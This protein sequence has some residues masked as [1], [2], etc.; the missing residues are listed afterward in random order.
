MSLPSRIACRADVERLLA[1][2]A[3]FEQALPSSSAAFDLLRMERLLAALGHPERGPRTWHV[4]GSK[5]KGSTARMLAAGLRAAGL[6]PVGLTTSPHLV[7]LAERIEVDGRPVDDELLCRAF[8]RL[9]PWM[10]ATLGGRL[11][12][13]FFELVTAAAWLAFRARDCRSV[14][15]E[16]GL[17]GRLDA[18]NVCRPEGTAITTIELEHVA[19]L[20]DT[21]EAI[22]AEK[23]GILKPGVPCAT[24]AGGGALRVIEQRAR[25]VGAPLLR[26][27]QEITLEGV[28]PGAGLR[29]C[30]QVQALGQRVALDLPL[31]G[32]HQARN[33]A[34]AT[35]LL[36]QAGVPAEAVREGLSRVRLPA[37]LELF[38]G[39][40]DVLLDGAHTEASARAAVEALESAFPGRPRVLLVA[41]LEEKRVE[42]ILDTLLP[43]SLAVVATTAPTPRALPAGAL[44]QRARARAAPGQPVHALDDPQ[45]A[46]ARARELCPA[47][48]LVL[49]T[50]SLYLAGTLR[51]GLL[52]EALPREARATP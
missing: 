4:T 5:G 27:G 13:T 37:S 31:L 36:L 44:A 20:G 35:A 17:G 7:D 40:P 43:G 24:A 33:A 8:D 22:A 2:C 16:V 30:A 25:E 15:L 52:R 38:A 21:V 11:A 39:R 28:R 29:T 49:A 10:Q 14:V 48:G 18:T 3:N 12:P 46:L 42:A 32:A 19:L 50:G 41:L 34:L 6:A 9:Q 1:A 26:L 23:A 47:G 45:A 51:A